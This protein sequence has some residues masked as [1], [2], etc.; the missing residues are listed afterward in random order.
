QDHQR[1]FPVEDADGKLLAAFIT[2]SNLEST[3]M[4]VVR[5]GNE[6]V[7]R[8]R[9]SDAAFFWEQ[10]RKAP[11]A[12]RLPQLDA[13]TFQ[14]QLGSIGDKVRRIAPVARAIAQRIGGDPELAERAATL[15]KCDLVT[16]LVGEFPELQGV[17][18]RYYAL[19]DGEDR[20]VA[21]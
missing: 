18:G 20:E 1:Y 5:A 16:H 13:V 8:P 19:A 17:M 3:D 6:R 9:L 15:A 11:L 21:S 2:V 12:T 7:V 10:D 4:E 14:A